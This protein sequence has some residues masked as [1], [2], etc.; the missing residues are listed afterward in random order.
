MLKLENYPFI[1][2]YFPIIV[3]IKFKQVTSIDD[4]E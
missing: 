1:I 3:A 2:K 4:K